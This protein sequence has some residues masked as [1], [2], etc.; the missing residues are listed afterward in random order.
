MQKLIDRDNHWYT[1]KVKEA[2][3]IL[4]LNHNNINRDNGVNTGSVDADN[5]KT[6]KPAVRGKSADA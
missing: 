5:Q 4:R 2:I 3:H 6:S 1:R